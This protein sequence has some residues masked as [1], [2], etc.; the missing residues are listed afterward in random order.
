MSKR[1]SRPRA[2][3]HT[4]TISG[5]VSSLKNYAFSSGQFEIH[6]N[7]QLNAVTASLGLIYRLYRYTR[8]KVT[9][10]PINSEIVTVGYI[11][12]APITSASNWVNFCAEYIMGCNLVT[13]V[14]QSF[15]VPVESLR[16]DH[17]WFVTQGDAAEDSAEIIGSI[18]GFSSNASSTA[19]VQMI[20]EVDYEFKG[21]GDAT[22]IAALPASNTS[23]KTR[24]NHSGT[25]GSCTCSTCVTHKG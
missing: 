4:G 12:G 5:R 21:V 14:P 11:A 1:S 17:N 3:R 24:T 7:D 19:N 25:P 9:L 10:L 15:V 2:S 6:V 13:S 20:I 23:R 16:T 8:V 22:S 18:C